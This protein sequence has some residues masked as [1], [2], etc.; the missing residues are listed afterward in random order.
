VAPEPQRT[1]HE[2][3][4]G[5][6]PM[7]E[8]QRWLAEAEAVGVLEPS[9]MQLATVDDQG[10]P[11]ARTVLLRGVDERGF[12]FFTNHTS[13]KGVHLAADP[14][15]ALVLLWMPLH[16]QVSVTGRARLLSREESQAYWDTRPRGSQIGAWA[17]RQSSVLEGRAALDEA[18]VAVEARFADESRVPLPPF[19]GGYLVVP[20]SVTLWQGR[21][22][23]LHDRL[24]WRRSAVDQPWTRERLSP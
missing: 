23:R 8:V 5:D 1:L 3:D 21:P 4:V 16:R 15:C 2:D 22:D 11:A 14:A 12:R 17:S 24:R 13:A 6:D 20:D 18:V 10:R 7:P 9:A 19:W